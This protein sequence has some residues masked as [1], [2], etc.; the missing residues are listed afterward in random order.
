M[1]MCLHENNGVGFDT[2]ISSHAVWQFVFNEEEKLPADFS[3]L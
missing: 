3:R 1:C 2:L